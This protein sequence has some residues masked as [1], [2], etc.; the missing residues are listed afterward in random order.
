MADLIKLAQ[1]H[2]ASLKAMVLI[3]QHSH[4]L[5]KG[6]NF[7]GSHLLFQRI[8]ES[9]QENLDGAAEKFVATFGDD[10]LD[11]ST[12]TDLLG[13]VLSK[14]GSFEGDPFTMS[15]EME[16]QFL[17]LNK[18]LEDELEKADKLT[19]GMS[20]F[21]EGV[22]DNRETAIYLIQQTT[23]SKETK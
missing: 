12:Q 7:Y 2:L 6:P 18:T 4:W 9:A 13:K 15:L 10:V 22:A 11:W 20:N 1:L 19:Q 8:Y 5:S 16:K 14:M 17:N 3:H 23:K 21:L